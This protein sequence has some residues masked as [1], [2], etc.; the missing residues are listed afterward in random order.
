M[1]QQ[2]TCKNLKRRQQVRDSGTTLNGID[3]LEVVDLGAPD[4]LRQRVLEVYFLKSHGVSALAKEN[5]HLEGGERIRGIQV[6]GVRTE[7][8]NDR[9]LYLDLNGWGDYSIYQ[10]LLVDENDPSSPPSDFDPVLTRLDFSFKIDCPSD[11]DCPGPPP[12][13]PE[14]APPPQLDYLAK[15]YASFRRLMLDRLSVTVP[16]WQERNAADASVALVEVLAYAADHLSYYQDAVATEAYLGTARKRA[17][18]RRHARLLDYHMHEGCNARCWISIEVSHDIHP[19]AGTSYV[20]PA[21]TM[22][23]TRLDNEPRVRQ[24][25]LQD[26][27]AHRPLVF[28][29]M[30]GLGSLLQKRNRITFYTWGDDACCL[31][32]GAT[33]ATLLGSQT[34]LSLQ[35]GDVLIFEEVIGAQSGLPEDADPSHRHAVRLAQ[36]PVEKTDPLNGETVL[37]VEWHRDDALP[38]PL[39]LWELDD[40]ASGSLPVSVARANVVLADHGRSFSYRQALTDTAPMN[41]KEYGLVPATIPLKGHYRPRLKH[42]GITHSVDYAVPHD[43]TLSATAALLQ[44]PGA[45]RPV[46]NLYDG[47]EVWSTQRDLL[48]S[49]RFSNEF[50]VEMEHDGRA[51]LRFGDGI[52]GKQPTGG[53]EFAASYRVGNGRV[54]NV[55]AEAITHIVTELDGLVRVRNPMAAQSGQDPEPMEQVRLYAP[56]AFRTQKRAVTEEDYARTAELFPE[57]QKA[58]A[59][60]RWTGSWYTMFITVDRKGGLEVDELFERRL[61]RHM[62]SYRLAGHDLEIDGPQLVSLDIAMSVCT[63][64]GYFA[65]DVKQALLET[66]GT[67]ILADGRRGFFHADNFT[68]GQAVHLSRIIASVM[69]VPGVQWVD[70]EIDATKPHHR[71]QRWG[72][73]EGVDHVSEGRLEMQRLE[74]ARLENNPNAP[75]NGRIEF[76]MEGGT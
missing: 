24:A 52:L 65:A 74:I 75:E 4:E 40:G 38:F 49:G 43:P 56:H 68:F 35:A 73:E 18:L 28:E 66:F 11:F 45:A 36:T 55:G 12:C 48:N 47:S 3:Y 63:K 42:Q 25:E 33:R 46:V 23:L 50:V 34:E 30:Y 53:T 20:F 9:L 76:L 21:G 72:E 60:R 17:S 51:Y 6:I 54:G 37:D 19:L 41:E 16:E 39:C 13:K 27:L 71:F 2:Y 29:T 22:L 69:K 70:V 67:G 44:E 26:R 58:V 64:P 8:S 14:A 62:E 32:K 61:R 15:D 31:P 10:L 7:P 5:F 59:T 1:R 57:V